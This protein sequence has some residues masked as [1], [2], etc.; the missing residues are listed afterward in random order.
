MQRH[1]SES[2]GFLK[3]ISLTAKKALIQVYS[4]ETA[5]AAM[6]LTAVSS[7]H[8][9]FKCQCSSFH[10]YLFEQNKQTKGLFH[11]PNYLPQ[12]IN[13]LLTPIC[14]SNPPNFFLFLQQGTGGTGC[15]STLRNVKNET[16]QQDE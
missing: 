12:K 6:S 10:W 13:V 8:V 9:C 14:F 4:Q 7:S 1:A 2:E 11:I 16:Y 5:V 3:T 15:H